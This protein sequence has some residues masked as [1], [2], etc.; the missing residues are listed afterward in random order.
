MT[1]LRPHLSP[2]RGDT[3]HQQ[4]IV[5]T[6]VKPEEPQRSSRQ[7]LGQIGHNAEQEE[8]QQGDHNGVHD[9]LL[10]VR[11][12]IWREGDLVTVVHQLDV[13]DSSRQQ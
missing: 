8:R 9:N 11:H 13:G 6:R 7:Q 2:R 3:A 12:D 10:P 1:K 5:G 4:L